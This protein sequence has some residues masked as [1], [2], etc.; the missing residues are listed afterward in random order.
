MQQLDL[1]KEMAEHKIRIIEVNDHGNK[2]Y[3]TQKQRKLIG[4]TPL[5]GLTINNE[6]DTHP[7][8]EMAEA[9]VTKYILGK[10]VTVVRTY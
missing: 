2:T 9:S 10:K 7:S 6:T 5:W 4:W 1:K 8:I 3:K